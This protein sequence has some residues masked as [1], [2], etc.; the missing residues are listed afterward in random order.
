MKKF[1][2]LSIL[3]LVLV[4]SG[5]ASAQ[6]Y[7]KQG[8]V[9]LSP[10]FGMI[11][12]DG[13]GTLSPNE[14]PIAGLRL[15]F[16]LSDSFSFEFSGQRAFSEDSTGVN[17]IDLDGYRGNLLWNVNTGMR[18]RPFLTAGGGWERHKSVPFNDENDWEIG[19]AS[20]RER[21]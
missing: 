18:V 8:Q 11:F 19:R 5:S 15:G 10:Y 2:I 7:G 17:N 1:K 12:P 16:W 9:E 21:V 3:A 20:C 4:M 13:Y 6:Q 14:A